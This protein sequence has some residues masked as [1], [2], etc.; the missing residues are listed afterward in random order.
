MK[1]DRAVIMMLLSG[2]LALP[3]MAQSS[4]AAPAESGQQPSASS[5]SA[6]GEQGSTSQSD[7]ASTSGKKSKSKNK[8]EAGSTSTTASTSQGNL[9]T[10]A[11]KD[12]LF[13]DKA[14]AGGLM[15]VQLGNAVKDKAQSPDVKDFANR[16]VT[17][18]TKANDELKALM[19]QKGLSAPTDLPAKDK[20][21][22]DKITAK[23]GAD[24]DKAYMADMVKDHNKDVKEFQDEAKSG[25]DPDVK[26][27]AAKTVATLQEHQKMAQ[28]IA[29]KVGASSKAS[30]ASKSDKKAGADTGSKTSQ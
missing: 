3:V 29:Q 8:G 15:E 2:A 19:Q 27:W 16:M 24:L 30:K 4:G 6:S 1:V 5:T 26:A 23:S 22:A 18:H 17:D 13:M 12:R 10:V 14:A 25:T 28:D 7:Q 11:R 21:T 9:K 20:A